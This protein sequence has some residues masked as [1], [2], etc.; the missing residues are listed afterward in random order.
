ML[1]SLVTIL[2][3]GGTASA[4]GDIVSDSLGSVES[5]S[6]FYAGVQVGGVRGEADAVYEDELHNR[7]YADD[8]RINGFMGGVYGGHNRLLENG[9]LIGVEGEWNYLSG[10]DT[11]LIDGDPRTTARL[12]QNWDASLRLRLGR[13]IGDYLPY[14]TGG[15]AWGDFDLKSH[16]GYSI[17]P[18]TTTGYILT[19]WTMG[20]GVEMKISENLHARIQYRYTD[21]GDD[22]K[23]IWS[24]ATG[25]IDAN[26]QYNAHTLTVGLS[27]RF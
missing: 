21:Y 12:E 15:V 20:A 4:G 26:V 14:L 10:N 18:D 7:F 3:L 22:T 2:S 8:F 17:N 5:W 6:G 24:S 27:Y 19:G 9:W 11:V 1:V 25:Y 13:V 23:R 16:D